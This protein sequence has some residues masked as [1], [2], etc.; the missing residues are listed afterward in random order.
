M[1]K[2]KSIKIIIPFL[3][4]I[5]ILLPGGTGRTH[6]HMSITASVEFVW[7][8]KQLSGAWFTWI[9]DD[10]FSADIIRTWD[11]DNNGRFDKEEQKNI[12]EQAFL[13]LKNYYYFTFIRQGKKRQNPDRVSKFSATQQN[14]SLV[15][16]FFIDL[17][18]IKGN[19][20]Y[21]SIYDYT[22]YCNIRYK[23]K[24]PVTLRYDPAR[25][26]VSYKI[27]KNKNFPV[28]Y[29]PLG[30]ADDTR[31]YY[32]WKRGLNTYYPRE[33]YLKYVPK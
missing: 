2:N 20:L 30:S 22:Y 1:K 28:Y 18:K 17:K 24:K 10:Y 21:L 9:F 6:P 14:G 15:Y 5:L 11:Q 8:K 4:C 26:N 32:K 7:D 16:R 13:N 33:I 3:M 27:I 25:L 23:K 29:D 19:S 12:Y 31:V